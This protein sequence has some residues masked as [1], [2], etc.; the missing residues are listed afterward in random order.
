MAREAGPLVKSLCQAVAWAETKSAEFQK[1]YSPKYG[2]SPL[3]TEIRA[4]AASRRSI[5]A[6]R[7]VKIPADGTKAAVAVLDIWI[8]FPKHVSALRCGCSQNRYT[9]YQSY[10]F[11]CIAAIYQLQCSKT[12]VVLAGFVRPSR[13]LLLRRGCPA[14]GPGMTR[15]GRFI[16]RPPCAADRARRSRG[17]PRP[18]CR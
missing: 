11:V 13:P 2:K 16:L 15:R 17:F 10:R 6:I 18:A 5:E 1:A 4:E 3:R 7:R 9:G 8:A 14:Q 12:A